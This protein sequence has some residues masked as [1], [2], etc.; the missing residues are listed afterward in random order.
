[1]FNA[2]TIRTPR[3]S[4]TGY[5]T[6]EWYESKNTNMRD[7]RFELQKY[8]SSRDRYTCPGCG[9]KHEFTRY[10]D[11]ETNEHLSEEV[12]MCNRR[13]QCG[14][15]YPP[16][17][18]FRDRGI[19]PE[20]SDR[21]AAAVHSISKEMME[22][23]VYEVYSPE[24]VRATHAHFHRN[25]FAGY[26]HQRFGEEAKQLLLR[27]YT[28]GTTKR[29]DTIFWLIDVKGN[30]RNG[31]IIP[32]DPNTGRRCK[33]VKPAVTWVHK[34]QPVK[35]YKNCFFG[36]R[37]LI[38]EPEKPVAI[39]EAP[40]TA[41]IA[42]L[43]FPQYVWLATCGKHGI[44]WTEASVSKVLQ[45]RKVFLFPDLGYD[46][47][48]RMSTHDMW[49]QK[50]VELQRQDINAEVVN[51]LEE[52]ATP[53]EKEQGLDLVDYLV[54]HNHRDFSLRSLQKVCSGNWYG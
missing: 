28:I 53:I 38:L 31:Q 8:R 9:Q 2:R 13:D 33:D 51:L 24:V 50:A 36:E 3:T 16:R 45:G 25:G 15:H 23:P 14:Y 54:R 17:E 30:A 4:R 10:V 32:Y 26:L 47:T 48:V 6:Y 1:M 29:G 18:Y 39:V 41:V 19:K 34:K 43:Y 44:R 37:L 5:E 46:K 20:P 52:M 42:S 12:G 21:A 35:N 40:K 27:R 49:R 7:F 11:T 22:E